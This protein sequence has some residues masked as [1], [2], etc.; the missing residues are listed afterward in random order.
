MEENGGEA[1]RTRPEENNMEPFTKLVTNKRFKSRS[2]Q[3][4]IVTLNHLGIELF[5]S[6]L[7][8]RL[9]HGKSCEKLP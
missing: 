6:I 2:G 9:K 7:E 3:F 1:T 5:W 8:A 4:K